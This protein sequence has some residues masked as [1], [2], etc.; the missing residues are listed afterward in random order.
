MSPVKSHDPVDHARHMTVVT[1]TACRIC[2][3]PGV[4]NEIRSVTELWMAGKTRRVTAI[5]L[6][7]LTLGIAAMHCVTTKTIDPFSRLTF[8]KAFGPKYAL[9]LISGQSRAAVVPEATGK[10]NV[11]DV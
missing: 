4:G 1:A 7:D 8:C 6:A 11:A 5:Q 9:I 2:C 3:V 10:L